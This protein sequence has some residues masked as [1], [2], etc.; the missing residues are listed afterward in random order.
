MMIGETATYELF[1][2]L[3]NDWFGWEDYCACI[4]NGLISHDGHLS[5][6]VPKRLHPEQELVKD[7]PHTPNVHFGRDLRISWLIEA[8]GS[9]V[10]ICAHSLRCQLNFVLVF[11]HNFAQTKVGDLDL[12]IVKEY[13]L[14]L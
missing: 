2:G 8:F 14:G 7:D 5:F 4:Q 10:P 9:L 13:V 11:A 3:W 12:S 1:A 6:V